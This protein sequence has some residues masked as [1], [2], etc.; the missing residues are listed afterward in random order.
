MIDDQLRAA[1]AQFDTPTLCNALERVAPERRGRGFTREPLVC[2]APSLAPIVGY[3]RT[4]RI[5]ASGPSGRDADAERTIDLAYYRYMA[6]PPH[7]TVC[8]IQD[9]DPQPGVGA[10]WG[11]VHSHV[12]QGLGSLGVVTNGS[13]RDLDQLARGFQLLAGSVSP[14]HAFVHVVD[15]GLPVEVAGM[16][17]APGDLIHADR[18]GAVVVPAECAARL[19][20]AARAIVREERVLIEASRE[21]GFGISVLERILRPGAH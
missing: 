7:P 8:V 10:W 9:V 13:I 19:P 5:R 2:A 20:D 12:H 3:A 6:S 11:E 16:P 15:Y 18:H 1:L 21:P 14:S 17:V 4:A